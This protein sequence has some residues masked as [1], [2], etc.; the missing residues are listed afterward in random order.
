M[1]NKVFYGW[2]ILVA[3]VTA[4][5]I[6]GG[7]AIYGLTLFIKPVIAEFGWSYLEVS[8][9][10]AITGV[11]VGILSPV[12][13]GFVDRFGSRKVVLISSV[14]VGTSF[15]ILGFTNS[16]F[17]FYLAFAVMAA[18]SSGIGSIPL[19]AVIG[20]WFR[21]RMGFAMGIASAGVGLGGLL[22]PAI[23]WLILT[24]DWRTASFAVGVGICIVM[25]AL[26]MVLRQRPE[27]Y[28]YYPDG[29]KPSPL[30]QTG[31]T[32]RPVPETADGVTARKA[33]TTRTFW[34]LA[35]AYSI[36]FMGLNAVI[37]HVVPFLQ[38]V[39]LEPATAAFL[40]TALAI[41]SNVGRVGYGYLGD[42]IPRKHAFAITFLSQ[43]L[44][45][46]VVLFAP[47]ALALGLFVLLYGTGYGGS[48]ALSS[49]MTREYFGR[50]A[51]GAIQGWFFA[52]TTLAGMAGPMFA[53]WIFDI[54]Q[55][56]NTAWMVFAAA[57][58]FGILAVLALKRNPAAEAGAH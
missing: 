53:G 50:I 10:I 58:A 48:V 19:Q 17:T 34:L 49:A 20:N 29:D 24:W 16:I 57:N 3:A 18:G 2:W 13:G 9:A 37:L 45:L 7:T 23:A 8:S 38:S 40:A 27:E 25:P 56:Y 43:A 51:F 32:G 35:L 26:A 55:S 41:I 46:T 12:I 1:V 36:Y 30:F 47:S 44:G 14:V 15:I 22:L 21:R 39:N 54:N 28:G 4:N 5:I 11:L 42:R 33:L 52:A 6:S 31:S